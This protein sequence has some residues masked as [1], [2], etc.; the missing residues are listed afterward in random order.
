MNNKKWDKE[1]LIHYWLEGA[2]DDF[3]TMTA[4]YDTKRYN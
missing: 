1:N 3:D 4:M 2:N